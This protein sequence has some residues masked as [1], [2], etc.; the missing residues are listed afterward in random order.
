MNIAKWL[1]LWYPEVIQKIFPR[2]GWMELII[3][4][5]VVI[6]SNYSLHNTMSDKIQK[7]AELTGIWQLKTA[8]FILQ[9]ERY[10]KYITRNCEVFFSVHSCTSVTSS[11]SQPNAHNIYNTYISTKSLLYVSVYYTPSSCKEQR[12]LNK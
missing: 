7:Y 9:N 2:K 12:V 1:P 4:I 3:I 6:P 10:T 8:N 5:D 11:I